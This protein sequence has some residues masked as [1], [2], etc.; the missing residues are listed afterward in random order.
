MKPVQPSTTILIVDDDAVLARVLGQALVGAGHKPVLVGDVAEARR[1]LQDHL[2]D[3]A[4]LDLHLPDGSGLDVAREMGDRYPNVPL[5]LMTGD[6]KALHGKS[7][8]T[9]PFSA[10]LTKPLDVAEVRRAVADALSDQTAVLMETSVPPPPPVMKRMPSPA[11]LMPARKKPLKAAAVRLLKSAVVGAVGLAL[12]AAFAAFVLGVPVPGLVAHAN[13]K[14]VLAPPPLA[15][16]MVPG[17]PHTLMVPEEV[18][19]ALEIRK[20][21]V[22]RAAVARVPTESVPLVLPGSTALDPTRLMRIRARFAPAKVVEIGKTFD[23]AARDKNGMTAFRELRSGDK[24]KKGDLLGVFYSVDVGSK[25]NDLIDALVQMRLD[26]DLL[27]RAEK[28]AG[29]V[30]EVLL[31]TY[32]RN[33][34][35]DRN[36]IARALNMLKTWNIPEADIQAVRDEADQI[37]KQGGKRDRMKEFAKWARVELRAPDAGTIVER[38]VT[39]HEIVVDGTVNLFQVAKVDRLLVLANAPE[40]DLPTLLKLPN[41]RRNWTIHPTAGTADEGI[42][43]AIDDIS[44]LIDVNQHNAIV[45]GHIDNPGGRLRAGQFI[46]AHIKMPAPEDVVEIPIN[47]IVDDGRQCVVFV[48]PDPAKPE[49]TLRRVQVT[50][51]FDK[52]AFVRSRLKRKKEDR[53]EKEQGLLAVQPLRPGERV[54]TAGVLELKKEL[55]DRESH[56]GN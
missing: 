10:V 52:R 43:G 36:A 28:A 40:D 5:I 50:H 18:R 47:S 14:T 45:K 53:A 54:L 21:K 27:D 51:R 44:Y 24:V 48:Q 49:Y 30:P 56:G 33:V 46:E 22:D 8:L 34:E 26:K 41:D 20:G 39:Q 42:H 31:L 6:P 19:V 12:V 16:K 17:R 13:E 32:R 23:E 4:L 11:A 15:V 29:S 3:L 25:K 9:A 1:W 38:N 2:P 35:S 37:S 7:D 55:E